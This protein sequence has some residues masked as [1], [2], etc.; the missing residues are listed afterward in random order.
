VIIKDNVSAYKNIIIQAGNTMPKIPSFLGGSTTLASGIFPVVGV[1]V[2]LGRRGIEG[3]IIS[4]VSIAITAAIASS[5]VILPKEV[6]EGGGSIL[7]G[8]A[9]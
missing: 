9:K 7:P 6:E 2:A 8:S 3:F 4:S 1:R 5:V